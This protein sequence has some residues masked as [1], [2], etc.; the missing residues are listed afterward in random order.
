MDTD[1]Q[2][3]IDEA[4]RY[5]RFVHDTFGIHN[6]DP[7]WWLAV[8]VVRFL[9]PQV[10]DEDYE[11]IAALAVANRWASNALN[12]QL[13][14]ILGTVGPV[15]DLMEQLFMDQKT[16]VLES[17]ILDR[18]TPIQRRLLEQVFMTVK[19]DEN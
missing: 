10:T 8:I 9:F 15:P 12:N 17:G 13:E 5:Q 7:K 1:I 4:N 3:L 19:I 11:M 16:D 6:C 18:V 14:V 2:N